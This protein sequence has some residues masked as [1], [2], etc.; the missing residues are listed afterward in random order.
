MEMGAITRLRGLTR[1]EVAVMRKEI[2]NP[3]YLEVQDEHKTPGLVSTDNNYADALLDIE[4]QALSTVEEGHE[5][6]CLRRK[7]ES[8]EDD[9]YCSIKDHLFRALSLRTKV[10]NVIVEQDKTLRMVSNCQ[11]CE[12]PAPMK[13][14]KCLTVGYCCKEHQTEDWRIHKKKCIPFEI[15]TN[16][17]LGRHLVARRD[18]KPGELILKE[19]AL[20]SGPTLGDS[21][22]GNIAFDIKGLVKEEDEEDIQKQVGECTLDE[23]RHLGGKYFYPKCL[24]CYM[25]LDKNPLAMDQSVPLC[26][27]CSWPLCSPSCS[28]VCT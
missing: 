9:C 11:I 7:K 8:N 5:N 4:L 1:L 17:V 27:K 21:V 3:E 12:K 15:K 25:S 26:P 18:L 6:Y 14:K 13:C 24:G 19:S 22:V 16:E 2:N 23:A 10:N 20:V 28:K